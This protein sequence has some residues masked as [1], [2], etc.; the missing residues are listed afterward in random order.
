MIITKAQLIILLLSGYIMSPR[1][2]KRIQFKYRNLPENIFL[3]QCEK[4]LNYHLEPIR[5][6]LYVIH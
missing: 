5:K 6:N 3:I 2:M 1:L 4:E